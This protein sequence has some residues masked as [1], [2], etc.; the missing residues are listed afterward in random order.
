MSTIAKGGKAVYGAQ[1]GI[2][3]LEAKFPRIPGDMG[4]PATRA[5]PHAVPGGEGREPRENGAE[6]CRF[7]R[8]PSMGNP[9]YDIY[10]Q[11]PSCMP[12]CAPAIS[13]PSADRATCLSLASA[14]GI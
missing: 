9:V 10:S 2:L 7:M 1:L 11:V 3:M 8:I 4:N 5:V 6:R 12:V 14:T 13:G